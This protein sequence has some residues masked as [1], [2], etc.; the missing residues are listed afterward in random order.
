MLRCSQPL[1]IAEIPATELLTVVS[2]LTWMLDGNFTLL[3]KSERE[4]SFYGL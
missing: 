3:F 4:Y 2:T 1:A